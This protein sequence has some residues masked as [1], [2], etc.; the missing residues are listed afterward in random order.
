MWYLAVP[1]INQLF[2]IPIFWSRS[3]LMLELPLV[4]QS[5]SRSAVSCMP[6][7]VRRGERLFS[8]L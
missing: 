7:V 6:L 3:A 1:G 4:N 2:Q 5:I 8:R